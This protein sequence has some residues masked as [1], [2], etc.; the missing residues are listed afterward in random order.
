MR[1]SE[2]NIISKYQIPVVGMVHYWH[3]VHSKI[4]FEGNI[5]SNRIESNRIE[6]I[7]DHQSSPIQQNHV[8]GIEYIYRL[9]NIFPTDNHVGGRIGRP[10]SF[11]KKY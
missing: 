3:V 11:L 9:T 6:S 2:I 5:Y 4:D 7:I 10:I 8:N 1:K